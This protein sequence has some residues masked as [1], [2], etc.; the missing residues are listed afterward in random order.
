MWF[1]WLA[2]GLALLVAAGL[3]ARRRMMAAAAALGLGRRGCAAL[4]WSLV[5]LLYGYPVIV[6]AVVLGT[7]LLSGERFGGLDSPLITWGLAAP[8][9]VTV[10]VVFQALPYLLI[11][12]AVDR[13]RRWRGAPPGPMSRRRAL[14]ALAPVAVFAVYTPARIV[15]ENGELRWRHHTVE[16]RPAAASPAPAC[17]PRFRIAFLADVQQGGRVGAEDVAAVMERIDAE[18]PDIVLSGGDWINMGPDQIEAA[19]RSAGLARSRLGT[20]SVL[21]D[22]EHFAYRDRRRSATAMIEAM[23]AQGVAMVDDQIRRFDHHGRTIAVAFLTNSYPARA[24]RDQVDQLIGSLAGADF[25]VLVTHQL[26]AHIAELA[27]DRVDLVLAGHTHGGQVNPVVGLWHVP[28]ARVE[29]PYIDGRY[30]LGATTIIVTA[31]IGYSVAPFR[32]GAPGSVEIIDVDWCASVATANDG[33][34]PRQP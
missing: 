20:F 10:L 1:L 23:G 16:A 29:T 14:I 18:Q 8:F 34:I 13:V 11:G 22:H 21:G 26:D 25:S 3:Y 9:F 27:R 28:L 30:R 12:D 19:A 7:L 4:G 24:S 6:F 5:W 15:W 17:P 2:I 31:G 33:T 32:Y